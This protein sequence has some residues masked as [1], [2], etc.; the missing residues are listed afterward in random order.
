[1]CQWLYCEVTLTQPPILGLVELSL[2]GT[3]ITDKAI[4][5]LL[6][7]KLYV[8]W[9]IDLSNTVITDRG[10]IRLFTDRRFRSAAE[11]VVNST[12][13]TDDGIKRL[14]SRWGKLPRFIDRAQLRT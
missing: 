9:K 3:Q 6:R 8:R 12:K 10:L 7:G 14:E 13:V 11:I 1:M 4:E 2:S 5:S